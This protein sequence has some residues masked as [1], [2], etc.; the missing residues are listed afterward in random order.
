I[1]PATLFTTY[2]ISATLRQWQKRGAVKENLE[3]GAPT[4]SSSRWAPSIQSHPVRPSPLKLT[5]CAQ[6]WPC[7]P[8]LCLHRGEL[9][10][11]GGIAR[12]GLLPF[13]HPF[14]GTPTPRPEL[15]FPQVPTVDLVA[16]LHQSLAVE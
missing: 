14:P 7:F 16:H 4:G 13:H 3:N 9:A 5:F 15:N 2:V 12:A 1:W 6:S 11:A 8:R 10:E